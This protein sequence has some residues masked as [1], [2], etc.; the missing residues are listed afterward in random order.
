MRAEIDL[1][2][3]MEKVTMLVE[4]PCMRRF[5]VRFRLGIIIIKLG[6][7]IMGIPTKLVYVV[8]GDS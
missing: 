2:D 6:C 3:E 1:K 4:V 8:Q 5:V 7:V